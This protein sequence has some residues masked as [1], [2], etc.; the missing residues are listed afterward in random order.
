MMKYEQG[1]QNGYPARPQRAQRRRRT[2]RY[3]ES[4]SEVENKAGS[5]FQHPALVGVADAASVYQLQKLQPGLRLTAKG[6]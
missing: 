5:R 4:L 6:A 3:V 1:V 2:L